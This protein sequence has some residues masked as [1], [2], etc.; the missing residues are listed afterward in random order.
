MVVVPSHGAGNRQGCKCMPD[1][2][3]NAVMTTRTNGSC[4]CMYLEE[5][6]KSLVW[7]SSSSP[8]GARNSGCVHIYT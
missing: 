5:H 2:H 6:A 7:S 1:N 3:G 8:V 4:T